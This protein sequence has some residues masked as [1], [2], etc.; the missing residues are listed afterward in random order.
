MIGD[1]RITELLEKHHR[2]TQSMDE[3]RNRS[4]E[5]IQESTRDQTSMGNNTTASNDHRASNTSTDQL[6]LLRMPEFLSSLHLKQ[7][8]CHRY[9][10]HLTLKTYKPTSYQLEAFNTVEDALMLAYAMAPQRQATWTAHFI[11]NF[12]QPGALDALPVTDLQH[13]ADGLQEA[14][15]RR[16]AVAKEARDA[17]IPVDRDPML[18]ENQQ[19]LETLE[20][21]ASMIMLMKFFHPMG[22]QVRTPEL[23]TKGDLRV[24]LRYLFDESHISSILDFLL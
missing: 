15:S 10:Q 24:L 8:L 3:L 21:Q 11:P 4:P 23:L 14:L 5:V 19:E 20:Q 2:N 7:Q 12:S 1:A 18:L 22:H 6:S 16:R 13:Y 9:F 17:G